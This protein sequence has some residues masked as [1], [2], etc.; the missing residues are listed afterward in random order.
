MV[1]T[2]IFI[3]YYITS[4]SVLLFVGYGFIALAALVN[5]IVFFRILLK[6]YSDK[7]NRNQ[8]LR[9]C[10]LMLLNIPVVAIY[11]GATLTLLN[12]MRIELTNSTQTLLTD[13]NIIGCGGGQIEKMEAGQSKTVW[14]KITRDCLLSIDY[15]SQGQR[16]NETVSGYVTSGMGQKIKHSIDGKNKEYFY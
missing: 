2:L 16:K 9:T 5:I 10:G 15:L 11:F 3:F 8:L 14:V 4:F 12:V 7:I 13:V 6:A 1:G